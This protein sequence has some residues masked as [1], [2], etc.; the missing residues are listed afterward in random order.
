MME[1]PHAAPLQLPTLPDLLATPDKPLIHRDLSWLQFNERVLAEAQDDSNP[2]LERLKF[3]TITSTNLDEFFMIR[4]SSLVRSILSSYRSGETEDANNFLRIRDNILNAVHH[5]TNQQTDVFLKLAKNLG[6][7]KIYFFQLEK[8]NFQLQQIAETIFTTQILPNLSPAEP[9]N[10]IKLTHLENLQIAV[11][12]ENQFWVKVPRNLPNS[13]FHWDSHSSEL[14]IFFLDE[15]L[16]KFIV[17]HFS[18]M[19]VAY[20]FRLTRDGDIKLDLAEEDPELIP[21][22]VR[23][24][25]RVRERRG[26]PVR[27]QY[28]GEVPEFILKKLEKEFK[29]IPGQIQ[30]SPITFCLQGLGLIKGFLPKSHIHDP[31][32]FFPA[33]QTL[34]PQ[35]FDKPSQLFQKL[36]QEDLLLHHPYDSFDALILWMQAA[37]MDPY[38]T[39]IEQT[40]YRMDTLSPLMLALKSAAKSK[41]IR[42]VIELRAR[43]DEANNLRLADE[44]QQAGVEVSF[45]FGKLKLHGKVALVT[46]KIGNQT[47]LYAHLSTG[48]YNSMTARLY[49]DLAILTSHP[50]ICSDA[51]YFFDCIWAGEIPRDF[52]K[53]VSA[54]YKLHRRLFSHIQAE[55]EAAKAGQQ[56][57]IVA[58]VNALVDQ[59]VIQQLY[60]ASQA[61]VQVDLVVRGACS[62]IPGVIGLSENIRVISIVDRFLEHSRIYYFAHAQVMYL[63]SADW[64][65]RNFFSRLEIAFPVLDQ[66]IYRYIEQ[67]VI[68][69]Y[70]SDTVKARQ[71]SPQGQWTRRQLPAGDQDGDINKIVGKSKRPIRCQSFFEETAV[72]HYKSTPLWRRRYE[73]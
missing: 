16:F 6:K 35:P 59:S 65:P 55:T 19:G 10:P 18:K 40:V 15:L 52:K 31:R 2:L 5:F 13:Y 36:D 23:S 29:F 28:Y 69:V 51:R 38:V 30:K 47:R 46:R 20:L 49:T 11:I 37:C 3:L 14:F 45:G 73:K 66:N 64:M 27:L 34:I 26:R 42:V 8:N 24:N 4:Y 17:K 67:F 62:L 21:D 54:P 61:G 41:K 72:K 53:L 25:L 70:L 39:Q 56:A 22:L 71:L 32:L 58:K 44:L 1:T 50:E 68:P 9:F 60:R 43:F 57:R 63:S 48:N 7:S 12:L 33:P